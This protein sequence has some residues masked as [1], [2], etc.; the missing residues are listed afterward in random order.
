MTDETKVLRVFLA[1]ALTGSIQSG[2]R[3]LSEE[4]KAKFEGLPLRWAPVENIHLT[5]KFIG[6]V[7]EGMLAVIEEGARK[8]VGLV[9]PFDITVGGL[10]VFPN[11]RRP[12]IVWVGVQG[13]EGLRTLQDGIES[14][15]NRLGFPPEERAFS[16]HL[17][18]ARVQRKAGNRQVQEIGDLVSAEGIRLIGGMRVETVSLFRSHLKPSGA[19][20]EAVFSAELLAKD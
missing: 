8:Q 10:G 20:Y 18:L 5:L 19:E 13:A 16:P 2:L 6:D 17:T 15:M 11:A 4:L 14:E 3:E 1:I 9:E 7:P 12:R